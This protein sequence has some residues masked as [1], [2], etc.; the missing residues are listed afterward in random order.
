MSSPQHEH[1]FS[2]RDLLKLAGLSAAGLSLGDQCV[3]V[4]SA[5]EVKAAP[6]AEL[7]PLNRFPRMVQE[8]FVEQVREVERGA[9]KR[10]ASVRSKSDAEAYVQEVRAKI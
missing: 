7:P 9:D 1:L 3:A 6:P 8:Y 4:A 5:A 2:R 10:R